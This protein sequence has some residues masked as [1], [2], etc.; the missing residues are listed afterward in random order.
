MSEAEASAAERHE[1]MQDAITAALQHPVTGVGAGMFVQYRFDVMLRPDGTHKPYLPA[2]NTY[3]EIASECGFPGVVLYLI[4]LGSIYGAVRKTRNLTAARSTTDSDLL[5]SIA[6]CVEAALVYFAVCAAF[7]TCD[8]H[9][10]QFVLAGFAIAML[11]MARAL[12][13]ENPRAQPVPLPAFSARFAAK[14]A[15]PVAVG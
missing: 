4:F 6:L 1:L 9:P 3:L 10:H 5:W 14:P 7:M 11:R 13:A 8:K 12:P 2:H 15:R